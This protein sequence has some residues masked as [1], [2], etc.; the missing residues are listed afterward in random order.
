L[1]ARQNGAGRGESCGCG[2]QIINQGGG[3]EVEAA[4]RTRSMDRWALDR[5]YDRVWCIGQNRRDDVRIFMAVG[6]HPSQPT[7]EGES[8]PGAFSGDLAGGSG[9]GRAE[10]AGKE[11]E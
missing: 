11:D 8:I 4:L 10:E 3:R 6:F 9:K 2:G 1:R 7:G 5:L